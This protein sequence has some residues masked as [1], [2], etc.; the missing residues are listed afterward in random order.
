MKSNRQ[1]SRYS[2]LPQPRVGAE[3]QVLTFDCSGSSIMTIPLTPAQ[4]AKL[5][6]LAEF[7]GS[8]PEELLSNW[9]DE[10]HQSMEEQQKG[11]QE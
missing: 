1:K 11:E 2:R 5:Q 4:A 3:G 9:I 10:L 8:E 7:T 6:D